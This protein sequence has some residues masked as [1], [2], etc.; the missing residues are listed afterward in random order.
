MVIIVMAVALLAW[1]STNAA[2]TST[3]PTRP[4]GD[5]S[6]GVAASMPQLP[7]RSLSP[8]GV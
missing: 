4:T 5:S 6:A 3:M 2:V 1:S 8:A 7:Q